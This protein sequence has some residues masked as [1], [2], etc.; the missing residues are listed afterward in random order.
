MIAGQTPEAEKVE[1]DEDAKTGSL[2]TAMGVEERVR[3]VRRDQR[4]VMPWRF[5]TDV[6][7]AGLVMVIVGVAYLL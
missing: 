2:V 6:M 5:G 7:R 3:V 4:G 1:R